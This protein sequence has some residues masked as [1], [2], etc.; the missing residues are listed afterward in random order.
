MVELRFSHPEKRHRHPT[1]RGEPAPV[2]FDMGRLRALILDPAAYGEPSVR[3]SSVIRPS[4]PPLPRRAVGP[5]PWKRF[6]ACG[7]SSAPARRSCTACTGRPC[8]ILDGRAAHR[9]AHP[10]LA[11]PEQPDW[12]PVRLRPKADL[13]ALVVDRQPGRCRH[14]PAGRTAAGSPST[15]R[16]EL[17]RAKGGLGRIPRTTS[18]RVATPPSTS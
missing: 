3:A 11:L 10:V 5:K 13:R 4:R 9:R 6:C 17:A 14:L 1:V 2:Q 8:A 18:R 15:W 12:R 7:C 16:A